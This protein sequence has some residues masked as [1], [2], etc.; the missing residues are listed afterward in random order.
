MRFLRAFDAADDLRESRRRFDRRLAARI[1]DRARDS[2]RHRLFTVLT[3]N[4]REIGFI[5]R[6]DE[7]GGAA[8]V[9]SHAHVERRIEA[10]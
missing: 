4:I 5:E 9:G 6:V 10:K 8:A 1:H 3:K 2:L 7:I